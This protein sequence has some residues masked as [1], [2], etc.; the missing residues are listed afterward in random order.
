[1]AAV[2]ENRLAEFLVVLVG[3]AAL[4]LGGA[5]LA[6]VHPLATGPLYMATPM[7][8]GLVVCRRHGIP[9]SSVGLRRG[10]LRWSLIGALC[11]PP[12]ALLVA[13]VSLAVPGVRFD[14]SP[15]TE[16]V[17]VPATPGWLAVGLLA[18]I[19]AMVLVGVT[20]NAVFAFGEEFG[21]RGYLLYELA[22]LGFWRASI[23]IGA[24]WGLWHAPLVAFGLNY[25][26]FPLL[27]AVL[28][29]VVC[30]AMAPLF[31]YVVVRGRSVLPAT[32]LHGVFN[33]IGLVALAGTSDPV[34]RELV[35]SE[36]GLV[37]V[38]V[39]ALLWLF[40]LVRGVPS[41]SRHFDSV[42]DR[43]RRRQ[44]TVAD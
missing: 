15:V 39:F 22:P 5:T 8:A 1:M 44:T 13:G 27:G 7:I 10:R 24:L 26:S 19:I 28:F 3:T 16:A 23:A 38:L 37:G 17:G 40:L 34:R 21:W 14:P 43:P 42:S 36:G 18:L 33:A 2:S 11:W 25:P 4:V 20:I 9:V 35:A 41:L 30:V 31:T 6:G 32:F 12:I 29:V